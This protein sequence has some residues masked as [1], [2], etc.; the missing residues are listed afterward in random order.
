MAIG[1]NIDF[2]NIFF[3]FEQKTGSVQDHEIAR[4]LSIEDLNEVTV[5]YMLDALLSLT[6]LT[7]Y[8]HPL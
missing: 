1:V 4:F 5:P 8:Y 6:Y 7:F 2:C 3:S